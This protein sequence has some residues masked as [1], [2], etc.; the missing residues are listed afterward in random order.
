MP[1]KITSFESPTIELAR[2]YL[3][4]Q[5]M[6]ILLFFGFI[7]SSNVFLYLP[8]E[9]FYLDCRNDWEW[10]ASPTIKSVISYNSKGRYIAEKT[11]KKTKSGYSLEAFEK[12]FF[13]I[14]T[15]ENYLYFKRG[16][17]GSED[18]VR[19]GLDREHLDFRIFEDFNESYKRFR[20]LR[21]K[22]ISE[23]RA[24]DLKKKY[25]NEIKKYK[26]GNNKI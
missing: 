5:K 14:R 22:L 12:T 13:L 4:N 23:S 26:K 8:E 1:K 11:I 10:F 17:L 7:F 19:L 3:Y 18:N 2:Q 9:D 21:C 24:E 20:Y 25:E 16:T 15:S 6:R